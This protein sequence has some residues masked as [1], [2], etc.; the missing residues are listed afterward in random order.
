MDP[1]TDPLALIIAT[2]GACVAGL[3]MAV[4]TL[5]L[6]RVSRIERDLK[7]L[8]SNLIGTTGLTVRAATLEG[9]MATA[10]AEVAALK[11]N[12]LTRERFESA[13]MDQNRR[14]EEL[15]T[16]T[17]EVQGKVESLDHKVAGAG[18]YPSPAPFKKP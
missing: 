4:W 17:R 8:S 3:S 15:R 1:A 9:R 18:R 14:L 16:T 11:T 6:G 7:E 13:T 10:E 12:T 5:L 2:G